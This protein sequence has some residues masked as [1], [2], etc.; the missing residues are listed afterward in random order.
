M[1]NG[2]AALASTVGPALLTVLV[3]GTV[4][5]QAYQVKPQWKRYDDIYMGRYNTTEIQLML[6]FWSL[7]CIT[8]LFGGLHMTYSRLWTAVL[9]CMFNIILVST[10]HLFQFHCSKVQELN[11]VV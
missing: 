5:A 3:I 4:F 1:P 11:D 9:F 8:W 6:V 7:M 2:Y 10:R